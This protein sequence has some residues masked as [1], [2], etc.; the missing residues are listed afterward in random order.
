MRRRSTAGKLLWNHTGLWLAVAVGVA[1]F[2]VSPRLVGIGAM[3][4]PG[5]G[6][7]CF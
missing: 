7:C 2:F 4:M 3:L 1:I 5:T 6:Q